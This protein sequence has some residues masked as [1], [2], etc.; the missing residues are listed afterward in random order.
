MLGNFEVYVYFDVFLSFYDTDTGA[1]RKA[2]FFY[3]S[4]S[5]TV[6]IHKY[7]GKLSSTHDS[8]CNALCN[9]LNFYHLG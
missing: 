6:S 3:I 8:L 2:F 7:T 4:L 9:S 5:S 1:Q